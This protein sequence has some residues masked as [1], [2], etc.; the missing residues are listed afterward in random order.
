M[1]RA[2]IIGAAGYVGGELIRLL[3]R[4]PEVS[5]K[6]VQSN[7][8]NG[9]PVSTVH[10]DLLGESR[11]IFSRDPDLDVDLL[12]VALGHGQTQAFLDEHQIPETTKVIDM[13]QDFRLDDRF[14]Y[15]IT[16]INYDLIKG[17]RL[18]A[19]PGCF[20]TAILLGLAPL[21]SS[22]LLSNEVHISAITGSTGA[23]QELSDTTHFSWRHANISVYK[24]FSHQHLNEVGHQ[25][26]QL[27]KTPVPSVRF[28]P[29]RGDFT[30]GILAA[31]YT[32][33]DY[34]IKELLR[35]Y[36]QYYPGRPFV[37]VTDE[38]PDIKQVTGTNRCLVHI[39]KKDDQILI[40]SVIDNLLKGAA[41]QAVQN[42]N[43]MFG[44]DEKTGL[45]LKASYF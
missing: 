38:N 33:T 27:Q 8:Q 28:L 9:K 35:I 20:A 3:I 32:R 45:E 18:I 30:R 21:S 6:F 7:S 29:F 23:G 40:I 17:A 19:N 13:S 22:G 42:M 16:E 4:H 14:V 37:Y 44:L 10:R 39:E 26:S 5:L 25:L 11:L 41:G 1:I 2:G 31:M 34:S 12:F 43:I 24:A 15:G 36:G